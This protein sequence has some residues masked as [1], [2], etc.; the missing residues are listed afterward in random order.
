METSKPKVNEDIEIL[1]SDVRRLRADVV[2]IVHS[3]KSRSKDTVMETS[4]R[5]RG[6]M[7]DLGGKAADIGSK[8][9]EQVLDRT[10]ALKDRGYEVVENW[11]GGIEHRPVTSLLVA[12]AAGLVFAMF[13]TRRRY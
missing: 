9:K 2:G 7:T 3:A 6:M 8:A 12:F 1:K 13:I 4:D 11:R 5:I 10:E